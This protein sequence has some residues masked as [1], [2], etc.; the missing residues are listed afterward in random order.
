MDLSGDIIMYSDNNNLNDT[1]IS[2]LYNFKIKSKYHDVTARISEET[3]VFPDDPSYK[4]ETVCNV[5]EN[6]SYH[7]CH[8]HMGNHIG[9]HIDFPSHV[10]KDGKTS[11]DFSIAELIGHGLIIEVPDDILSINKSFVSKQLIRPKD[12]VF[13]KTA[14]SILPKQGNF[15]DKYVYIE[16]EAAEELLKKGVKIVGIDYLSVDQYTAVN[17]P[18]HK[19][20]LSNDVL[21]VEGLELKDVPIGR[22]EIYIMPIN[23]EGMDGLPARVVVK[24]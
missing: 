23:I 15:T 24:I 4:K 18:V 14:N 21:I 8:I 19:C 9:T 3:I 6:S 1:D 7:L 17:L 13:F 16:L 5:D 11:S 10:I 2:L 12:F 22:C 20:L